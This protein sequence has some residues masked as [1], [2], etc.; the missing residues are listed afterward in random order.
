M[1]NLKSL[2]VLQLNRDDLNKL[3]ELNKLPGYK[4]VGIWRKIIESS[5][6]S[7]QDV[8][9]DLEISGWEVCNRWWKYFK[10]G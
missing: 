7:R 3:S 4:G 10:I 2:E 6:R 1:G 8:N 5:M 9:D